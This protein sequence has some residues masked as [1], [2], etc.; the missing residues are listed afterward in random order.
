MPKVLVIVIKNNLKYRI[1]SYKEGKSFV[2][3]M[4]QM[5]GLPKEIALIELKTGN[6][7][8]LFPEER[9]AYRK[10]IEKRKKKKAKK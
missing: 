10:K 1:P 5:I 6:V 7:R 2:A 3:K 8:R 9:D 4:G